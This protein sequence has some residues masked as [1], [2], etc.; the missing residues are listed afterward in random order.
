[1]EQLK[2]QNDWEERFGQQIGYLFKPEIESNMVTIVKQF[3][4]DEY[5]T[6]A[7]TIRDDLMERKY[8]VANENTPEKPNITDVILIGDITNYFKDRFNV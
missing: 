6:L 4:E 3:I 8:T 1:M 2:Q 5:T 7:R